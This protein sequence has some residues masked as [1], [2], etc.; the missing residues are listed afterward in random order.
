MSRSRRKSVLFLAE[1]IMGARAVADHLDGKPSNVKRLM[2]EVVPDSIGARTAHKILREMESE[3][4]L[5]AS[6][7]PKD[8][9][10]TL[11]TPTEKLLDRAQRRWERLA[12][13]LA[14]KP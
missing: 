10:A 8:R 11:I 14:A 1:I 2:S 5:S 3:G 6:T 13:D 7:D 4:L 12:D 9:L